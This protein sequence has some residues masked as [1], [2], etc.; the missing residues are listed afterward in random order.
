VELS[1][2]SNLLAFTGGY[3]SK[4]LFRSLAHGFAMTEDHRIV[5]KTQTQ[6]SLGFVPYSLRAASTVWN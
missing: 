6:E 3:L 5:I 4:T 2:N 1:Q